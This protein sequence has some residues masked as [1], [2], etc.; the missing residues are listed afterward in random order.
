MTNSEALSLARGLV[1]REIAPQAAAHV[2][3]DVAVQFVGEVRCLLSP[4]RPW[5]EM[6]ETVKVEA[7]LKVIDVGP[8]AWISLLWLT[9]AAQLNTLSDLIGDDL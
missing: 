2:P 9:L 3:A 8:T 1:A 5:A 6:V 4:P 7:E